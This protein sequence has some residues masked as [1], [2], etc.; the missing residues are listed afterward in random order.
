MLTD[1]ASLTDAEL[2]DL[3]SKETVRYNQMIIGLQ[4]NEELQALR[5]QIKAMLEEFQR[6]KRID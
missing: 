5:H 3:V 4:P 2:L 6:R 1:Y